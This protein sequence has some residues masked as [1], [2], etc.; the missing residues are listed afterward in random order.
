MRR[1]DEARED[2]VAVQSLLFS[3][4]ELNAETI[5]SIMTAGSSESAPPYVHRVLVSLLTLR[6]LLRR[7][8][9]I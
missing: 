3:K 9:L 5:L 6:I 8:G 4:D 2:R 7:A 1:V